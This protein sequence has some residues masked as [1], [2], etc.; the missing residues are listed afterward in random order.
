MTYLL[1]NWFDWRTCVSSDA[2]APG[3]V[4][5]RREAAP[6]QDRC[7]QEHGASD[8]RRWYEEQTIT[9]L[10]KFAAHPRGALGERSE[11]GGW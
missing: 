10:Q 3:K 11:A 8:M 7:R 5:A 6:D 9:T 4:C 1:G 2:A